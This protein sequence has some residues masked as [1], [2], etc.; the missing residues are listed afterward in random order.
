MRQVTAAVQ[1]PYEELATQ[2]PTEERLNIDETDTKQ[3]NDKAWLW[4]FVAA[5]VLARGK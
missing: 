4:T 1:P 2:L 3:E 5:D